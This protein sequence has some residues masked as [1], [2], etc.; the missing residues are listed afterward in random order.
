VRG[1]EWSGGEDQSLTGRAGRGTLEVLTSRGDEEQGLDAALDGLQS[2]AGP[3]RSPHQHLRIPPCLPFAEGQKP[4]PGHPRGRPGNGL[5]S[6]CTDPAPPRTF[7]SR[8]ALTCLGALPSRSLII[9]NINTTMT[10]CDGSVIH[11][12]RGG[13]PLAWRLREARGRQ[14]FGRSIFLTAW[15][16]H[17]PAV[18][19]P[20]LIT[21]GQAVPNGCGTS[22]PHSVH[23]QYRPPSNPP[24]HDPPQPAT[25]ATPPTPNPVVDGLAGRR[26]GGG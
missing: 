17:M 23:T 6:N 12:S 25:A 15:L 18:R 5:H 10:A 20:H 13:A 8:L 1:E 22:P 2:G 14:S 24:P 21:S 3:G 4:T 16:R 19:Q 11:P 7:L 9:K 26:A